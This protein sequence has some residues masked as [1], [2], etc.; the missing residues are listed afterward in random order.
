MKRIIKFFLVIAFAIT[1]FACSVGSTSTILVRHD[2]GLVE[3]NTSNKIS[4]TLDAP[5][6]LWEERIRYRLLY[7]DA[8]VIHYYH[9]DR[10]EAPIPVLLEHRLSIASKR[11][12]IMRIQLNQFEQHFDKADKA[13]V[14]MD[15]TVR[16]FAEKNNKLLGMRNFILS[17]ATTSADAK[18]AIAGF[19]EM[20]EKA[21]VEIQLWLDYLF[22]DA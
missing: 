2:L 14:V 1:L 20:T 22:P 3:G 11:P 5:V 9:K 15:L 10:W 18:G 21:N 8:T 16:V 6:W 17:Q 7:D 19:V 12:L 4:I 13:H